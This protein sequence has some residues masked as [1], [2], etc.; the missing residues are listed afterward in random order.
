MSV[1]SRENDYTEKPLHSLRIRPLPLYLVPA[2]FLSIAFMKSLLVA[3]IIAS[4]CFSPGLAFAVEPAAPRAAVTPRGERAFITLP[5]Q[6]PRGI[7][8]DRDGNLYVADVDTGKVYKIAPTG[9]ASPVEG[10]AGRAPIGLALRED[11][12]VVAA[13]AEN[14]SVYT[15][16][17]AGV[18][19]PVTGAAGEANFKSPTAVAVDSRGLV[20]VANN[21]DHTVL[22]ITPEGTV[23]VF[24]GLSGESG[25]VDGVGQAAR[26]N[27]PLGLAF[28]RQ[29][30][31]Y[32][33]DKDNSNIRKITTEGQVSTLA[34][35]AGLPGNQDGPRATARFAQPR[36]LTVD[37]SGVVYVADTDNYCI[38]KV[39]TNGEVTTLAGRGGQSGY[40][41]GEGATARFNDPRGITLDSAG[42]VYVADGGNAAIRQISPD[43]AV[44][45]IA[46]AK[47]PGAEPVRPAGPPPILPPRE[48]KTER[49]DYSK[50]ESMEG[51][52]G[53]PAYWSVKDGVFTAKG[54]KVPSTFLLTKSHYSDFRVTLRSR[55]V[56]SDNHAGVCFWGEHPAMARNQWSYKGPLVIFPG[57]S[58][59]D[60]RTNKN[61]PIDPVGRALAKKITGQHDWILVEILAQG[62]RVRVA[63]NGQQVLDWRDPE[64]S[65]LKTGPIGLQLHGYT[66]P[67]EVAY[68][69]V[70][71]ESFP[72]E[73]RLITVKE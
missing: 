31:L 23:S 69:D 58:I 40:V 33:A 56:V 13:D 16:S 70:V 11:G 71:I 55:M 5:L 10:L 60:Y 25:A 14:N 7:A 36:A 47:P 29:G 43:G 24:A 66:K 17:S 20:F 6:N 57:L 28:D 2:W 72:K 21:L 41:D 49:V 65:L 64:P 38:R 61:V 67:Q 1:L 68:K 19:R 8:V 37:P 51:W 42:N 50:A 73:D 9:D 63:Y 52:D 26:F 48:G 12:A 53:D 59:W 3:S 27:T 62:N 30:N 32:L 18:V 54:E 15:I 39:A 4:A 35:V 44:K 22:R 46:A 45:T 34:G